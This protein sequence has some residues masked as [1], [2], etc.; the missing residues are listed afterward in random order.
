MLF[1]TCRSIARAKVAPMR[2]AD[3]YVGHDTRREGAR[4]G[5]GKQRCARA[6]RKRVRWR[7]ESEVG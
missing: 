7:W 5:E 1:I 3:G 6:G 4:A 2:M